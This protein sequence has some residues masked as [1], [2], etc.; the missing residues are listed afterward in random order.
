M[1]TPVVQGLAHRACVC[2][3]PDAPVGYSGYYLQPHDIHIFYLYYPAAE[4]VNAD[5]AP[6]TLWMTGRRLCCSA[7]R[8]SAAS[9]VH[10]LAGGPGCSSGMRCSP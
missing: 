8:H 4:S 5:T 7:L 10:Q 6:L 3:E 2:Q 1:S 9:D